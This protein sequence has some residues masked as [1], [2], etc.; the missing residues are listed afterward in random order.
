MAFP[1]FAAAAGLS[2]AGAALLPWASGAPVAWQLAATLGQSVL[3]CFAL[4]ALCIGSRANEELLRT[5][6]AWI[7]A[8]ALVLRLIAFQ[9]EPL[10][11]DDHYRYLWDGHR[12]LTALDPYRLAPAA[13]FGD[14]GVAPMWQAVLNGINHPEVPTIYG[15]LLQWLFA[16]GQWLT[17]A[18]VGGVQA[19][20]LGVD[21]ATL[22]LL[23]GA[24]VPLVCSVVYALH[25]VILKEAIT[26]AHPDGLLGLLLLAAMLT[27]R[28]TRPGSSFAVGVL[29]ALA[30]ATKVAALL[31][32]P[33]FMLRR[34]RGRRVHMA[35]GLAAGLLLMYGPFLITGSGEWAGLQAFATTWRFNPLLFRP[36][37]ALLPSVAARASAAACI[38]V[39]LV[40]LLVRGRA[41]NELPAVDRLLLVLLLFSPVVNPWYWLWALAPALALGHGVVPV[42]AAVGVLSYLN[43]TV[44]QQAGWACGGAAF[45]V[46]VTITLLQ[47]AAMV[48]VFVY[49]RMARS[50]SSSR[51]RI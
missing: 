51:W 37:D 13:Y 7:F 14:D 16:L 28:S 46:P 39:G 20:L 2:V 43:G 18:K 35:I 29:L 10:L 30:L 6:A 26:S 3:A 50:S 4:A 11:E 32:L 44:L 40:A 42:A 15:P 36:L 12:T 33:L 5:P 25:P 23:L 21:L 34:S 17:P 49:M 8:L 27:W 9:G 19:I 24:R 41:S 1:R 48:G 22:A 31:V 47:L 38:L 45:A